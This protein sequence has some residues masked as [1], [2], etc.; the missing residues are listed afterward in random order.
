LNKKFGLTTQQAEESRKLHGTNALSIK[1]AQTIFEMYLDSFKDPWIIILTIAFIVK[2][3]LNIFSTISNV[4]EVNW[5]ETVGLVF[6][7]LLSTGVSTYSNY[8]NQQ[9][10]N[11]LQAENS[12]II[13][14]VYR[15]YK[16]KELMI[17]EIVKGDAILLQAG[18]KVPA[19]GIILNG[20]VK[21]DQAVL[22]GESEEAKKVELGNNTIPDNSDTYNQYK[23]FRG[24]TIMSGEVVMEATELGDNTLLGTINTSL[25][26]N[27]KK[28]PSAEKLNVLGKSIGVMGY[29][30]SA[31]YILIALFQTFFIDKVAFDLNTFSLIAEIIMYSVTIIIMAVPEGLPMMNA[32]VSSMNGRRLSKENILVSHNQIIVRSIPFNH[33]KQKWTEETLER[34][35]LWNKNYV[36]LTLK[37]YYYNII[38]Y[39]NISKKRME[40]IK[41]YIKCTC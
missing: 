40:Y 24:T 18:D 38:S 25:Q 21:V 8:K 19:D 7:I 27:G 6:A 9:D 3:V 13:S 33:E 23:I 30:A 37:R 11:T 35:I 26:E 32:L 17:D 12:K 34:G 2:L 4:G 22:N 1:E 20:S 31:I 16:L 14:K 28:S 29:T 39:Y 36:I 5:Y 41:T 10:F 15:D